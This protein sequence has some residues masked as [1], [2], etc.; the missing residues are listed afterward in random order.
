MSKNATTDPVHTDP[1]RLC[2]TSRTIES[3]DAVPENLDDIDTAIN[4]AIEALNQVEH[5]VDSRQLC[6]TIRVLNHERQ[7]KCQV[8]VSNSR[9]DNEEKHAK[10]KTEAKALVDRFLEK[11][12]KAS[13]EWE[14]LVTFVKRIC[15]HG[16]EDTGIQ[17]RCSSRI[18]KE[19]SVRLKLKKLQ[20]AGRCRSL[21]AMDQ[22]LLDIAGVRICLY[23]PSDTSRVK[24]IIT[25]NSNFKVIPQET[26]KYVPFGREPPLHETGYLYKPF[27]EHSHTL[28]DIESRPYNERMGFY[29][30]DHYWIEIQG[31]QLDQHPSWKSKRVEIQVRS[32]VMDAWAEVRHDLDYKN[33]LTGYPGEDELRT[34][35]SIK[36][37]IAT[38]EILLDTLR[39]QHDDRVKADHIQFS[40]PK[41]VSEQEGF[42]H[43]ILWTL[44][45]KHSRIIHLFRLEE[46]KGDNRVSALALG[47]LMRAMGITTPAKLREAIMDLRHQAKIDEYLALT[48]LLI[49]YHR[50]G[51]T[52]FLNPDTQDIH[53]FD[54]LFVFLMENPVNNA[55]WDT[56][57][58]YVL[59]LNLLRALEL[60]LFKDFFPYHDYQDDEEEEEEEA[61]MSHS[62]QEAIPTNTTRQQI[63]TF[64]TVW[65]L[66]AC[67]E[68]GDPEYWAFDNK[69]VAMPLLGNLSIRSLSIIPVSSDWH[70]KWPQFNPL[71]YVMKLWQS[72]QSGLERVQ[73]VLWGAA[74]D[75]VYRVPANTYDLLCGT[76]IVE[77]LWRNANWATG[78]DRACDLLESPLGLVNTAAVWRV[79]NS[80][81]ITPN[82]LSVC[83]LWP[84]VD[85]HRNF[86]TGDTTTQWQGLPVIAEA[87]RYA[88]IR[89]VLHAL[90][91][92]VPSKIN[93]QPDQGPSLLHYAALFGCTE[94]VELLVELGA[95]THYTTHAGAF[96]PFLNNDHFHD[97]H[98]TNDKQ[99]TAKE[100]GRF[101]DIVYR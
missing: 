89:A 24:E 63:E 76:E 37:S 31:E 1:G 49:P 81:Q 64:S 92:L 77:D 94:I 29:D 83:L 66:R 50:T 17:A 93:I 27:R 65:Y 62:F 25:S 55:K 9:S 39:K 14:S 97:G 4:R 96:K 8:N 30:A 10:L 101:A 60:G 38:C 41:V 82:V 98:L 45:S 53:L 87:F 36:G 46:S 20:D 51:Q 33:I 35:D 80:P 34:L 69:L 91:T 90:K 48:Q 67:F 6:D 100:L 70:R 12:N 22:E 43:T 2:T 19:D 85:L 26:Y 56:N 57:V 5:S 72:R 16:L 40:F 86:M 75:L 58:S 42:Q 71:R 21:E 95:D 74:T 23:F 78:R 11:Y 47:N 61:E 52:S 32:V 59:G 79:L 73:F 44:R 7:R 28:A 18:K 54:F 88:P 99:I 68:P 3:S 15:E 84:E 13:N